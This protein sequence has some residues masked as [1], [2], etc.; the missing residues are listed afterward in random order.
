MSALSEMAVKPSAGHPCVVLTGSQMR[1]ARAL[2]RWS[3]QRLAAESG[4][5]IATIQRAE[6]HDGVPAVRARTLDAIQSALERAGV[7]FLDP[8]KH[9]PGGAGVRL[10]R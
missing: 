1:A 6:T 3:H 10:A 2:L 8:G 7:V 4:I 5:G 9:E